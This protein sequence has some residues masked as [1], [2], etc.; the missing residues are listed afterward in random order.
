[1]LMVLM[2]KYAAA[3]YISTC[4]AVG[5]GCIASRPRLTA[6]AANDTA[7]YGLR[8]TWSMVSAQMNVPTKPAAWVIRP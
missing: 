6:A 7:K 2:K 4:S 5:V 8:P 1:M 3:T